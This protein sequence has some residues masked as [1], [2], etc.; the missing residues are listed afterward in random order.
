MSKEVGM[1]PPEFAAYH[2]PA[3]EL[4][5]VKHGLIV[6]ALLRAS[7]T[8]SEEVLCWTLGEPGECAIKMGH[9]SIVLGALDKG[10]CR[11][12][13]D[14]TADSNYPGVIGPDPTARWFTDRAKELGIQFLEPVQQQIYS[15]GDRPRY[16]GSP[17]H[18]RPATIADA[19]LLAD[20]LLW[21]SAGKPSRMI[22]SLPAKNWNKLR[23]TSG[24]YSG[25]WRANPCQWRESCGA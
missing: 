2:G 20:W 17:G 19:T 10:Q 15:I 12:L 23:A 4:D 24:F 16:P 5:E 6:N 22:R 11:R 7:G 25:L 3:L 14:L 18:A 9:H 1:T 21:P 13:A 8:T